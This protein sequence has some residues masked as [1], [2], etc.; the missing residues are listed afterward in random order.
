[1]QRKVFHH[2]QQAKEQRAYLEGLQREAVSNGGPLVGGEGGEEGHAGQALL[3]AL[4]LLHAADH[5]DGAEGAALH[6]PHHPRALCLEADHKCQQDSTDGQQ[7]YR[8]TGRQ[9]R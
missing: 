2:R 7:T 3:I 4:P 8:Q 9:H 5:Y 6:A 1:M